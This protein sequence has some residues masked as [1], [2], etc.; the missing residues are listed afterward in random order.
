[1]RKAT[2]EDL[3]RLRYICRCVRRA[4]KLVQTDY[5]P[6]Y[7]RYGGACAIASQVLAD[8]LREEGFDAS[9]ICGQGEDAGHCWVML[10]VDD[11]D[12][13]LDI[14]ATQFMG[15]EIA[16]MTLEQYLTADWTEAFRPIVDLHVAGEALA[17]V[18]DWPREQ[19]PSTW[20]S[21][22]MDEYRELT[23]AGVT[24][25]T[26]VVYSGHDNPV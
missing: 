3:P 15:P 12:W 23:E 7:R 26:T 6:W 14:T 25:D 20:A 4:L 24:S 1:M 21:V 13:V 8:V 18:E 17:V 11:E 9:M 16:V 19:R 5:K 2:K 10:Q 22:V